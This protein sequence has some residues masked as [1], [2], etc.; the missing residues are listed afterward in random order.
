M[1][2]EQRKKMYM[3]EKIPLQTS[4]PFITLTIVQLSIPEVQTVYSSVLV[5]N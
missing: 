5:H 1:E 4:I 2:L 3:E